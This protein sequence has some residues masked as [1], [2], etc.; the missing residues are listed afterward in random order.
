[1]FAE[2][3][4]TGRAW[5]ESSSLMFPKLDRYQQEAYWALMDIERRHG[6]PSSATV[7]VSARHSLA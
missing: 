2:H 7:S 3:E 1:M 6:A 4:E 5:D